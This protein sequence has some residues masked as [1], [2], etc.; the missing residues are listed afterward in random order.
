[1]FFGDGGCPFLHVSGGSSVV[2]LAI[3][4]ITFSDI[5]Y[6]GYRIVMIRRVVLV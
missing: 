3:P 2:V 6:P 1:M 5:F 4:N